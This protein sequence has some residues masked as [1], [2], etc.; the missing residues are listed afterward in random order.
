MSVVY[1]QRY[2]LG[3]NDLKVTLMDESGVPFDPHTISYAFYGESET[4]GLWRVGHAEREPVRDSE[5]VYYSGEL[6][7]SSFTPGTY[8]I[9]WMIRRTPTSPRE[10]IGR[11]EFIV[12]SY[13]QHLK[14]T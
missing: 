10:I 4:R 5:G 7:S 12:I 1:Y 9:E 11:K 8:Y 3:P 13:S 2:Q 6:I 14:Y